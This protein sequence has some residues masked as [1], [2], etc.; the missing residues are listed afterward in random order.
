MKLTT[1]NTTN[2]PNARKQTANIG[3]N[4][5]SGTLR[6][7]GAAVERMKLKENMQVQFH[8]DD[9]NKGDWYLEIVKHDGFLLR[10]KTVTGEHGLVTQSCALVRKIFESIKFEGA[11]GQILIAAEPVK[12]GDKKLWP[13]ITSSLAIN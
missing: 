10:K 2:I 1:F 13:L 8:H 7:N 3:V 6:I 12:D 11:S 9:E 4:Q 5:K